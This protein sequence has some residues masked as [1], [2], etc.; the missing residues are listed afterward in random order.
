[1]Y[2]IVNFMFSYNLIVSFEVCDIKLFIATGQCYFFITNISCNDISFAD[3]FADGIHERNT[4]LAF[5]ASN[6]YLSV[7]LL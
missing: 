1:M 5:A 6:K 7:M 4:D 3:N 2:Y